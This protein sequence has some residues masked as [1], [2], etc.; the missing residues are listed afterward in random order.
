MA[1][2]LV[3]ESI[4]EVFGGD[5]DSF[6]KDEEIVFG[7]INGLVDQQFHRLSILEQEV[8]YWLA[9][10]REAVPLEVIRENSTRPVS[11]GI[12]FE[13]VASLQRRSMIE[14]RGS[15]F[16][17][18]QPV[19]MEYVTASLVR[20]AI[21][22]F[23]K[24]LDV[25]SGDVWMNFALTKAQTKEYVRDSQIRLILAPIDKL[26]L[27]SL[28]REAIEQ[29][30]KMKLSAL[31]QIHPQPRSY[32]AG[33]ALNLLIHL[34]SD[35]RGFDFS[36]LTIR[37][38]Y[39]Q[40]AVLPEVD[41][42]SAHF[43]ASVFTNSFGNILSVAF[44]SGGNLLAAGTATG[45]IWVYQSSTGKL[46]QTFREHRDA[47]WSL[48]FHSNGHILVSSS[49]D[50]TIRIWD[51]HSGSCHKTLKD[52]T[53]RVRSAVLS[54]DGKLLASGSDD[55]TV[56]LWDSHTGKCSSILSGH[57]DRIWSVAFSP[58]GQTLATGGTDRT[59]RLWD[60]NKGICQN[61]LQGHTSWVWSVTFS[62]DGRT[63]A[64]A[65]EDR[66]VRLWDVTSGHCLKV[67]EGHQH[68]VR[69]VCFNP[70]GDTLASASEDQTVRLGM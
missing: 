47:V 3:S 33:N 23:Y 50:Q 11:K 34:R 4:Q 61:I 45:E 59:I 60:I 52:H 36:R 58:N 55:Q 20:R 15:T 26:L 19:V 25:E 6:L 48:H 54:P 30:L 62:P 44:S 10:E 1:L 5:I 39:L 12:F 40:N 35:L 32:L 17:T 9:I 51:V 64:S 27:L 24:E 42:S 49:D 68:E 21:T 37:Q 2:K 31:R 13:V 46:L 8:L 28:G 57:S 18:L 14:T 53:N 70:D 67:L 69:S 65:S 63:L 29:K 41:F 56:R 43:M 38:A 16:L 22:D 7:D 66:T